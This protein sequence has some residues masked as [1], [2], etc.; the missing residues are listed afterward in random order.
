MCTVLVG[1][2]TVRGKKRG[3]GIS[4]WGLYGRGSDDAQES[5]MAWDREEDNNR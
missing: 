1:M 5:R 2:G 4:C 3:K